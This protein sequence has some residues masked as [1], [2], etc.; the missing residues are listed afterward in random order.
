ML[1]DWLKNLVQLFSAYLNKETRVKVVVSRLETLFG[2]IFDPP[3]YKSC[4]Y[5][6]IL[7]ELNPEWKKIPKK[8]DVK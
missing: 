1:H 5:F 6:V 8:P 2:C 3:G 4:L 7:K